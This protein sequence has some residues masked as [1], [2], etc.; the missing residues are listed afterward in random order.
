MHRHLRLIIALSAAVVVGGTGITLMGQGP[1][2]VPVADQFNRL[3][4]RS[5]GPSIMSGRVT[6]FAVYEASPATFYVGTAHGGVWKTTDNGATFAPLFQNDGLM[7]VGDL[8][9]SQK[10]PNLVW[11]GSGEGNN[12]QSISWGD[13]IFK[14]TDGGKTWKNMGLATSKHINRVRIDP[15][16]NNIV[17]VAAQ[18]PLFESGGDRG[19]YKTTDGGSTWKQ[20]L[21][22]DADTGANDLVMDPTN[23]KILYASTYQRRRSQCCMNGGGPGS[24]VWKSTDAGETWTRLTNGLPGPNLGR[25][26][27]DVYRKS[28]NILYA[29]IEAESAGGG[30][31]GGGTNA[32]TDGGLYRSDDA[33]GSWHRVNAENA[34]PMYFGQVRVD[35]TDADVVYMGGVGLHM[36]VDGGKSMEND[37]AREIHDDVHAIWIDPSNSQHLM[38]GDD[39][40]VAIS[41]DRSQHWIFQRNIVAGLFYHIDYDMDE[42]YRVCGG[43]QDNYV[44]CGPSASRTRQGI[45]DLEWTQVQGGDGFVALL[46]KRNSQIVYSETQDG[47][48]ARH[49]RVTGESKGIRPSASNVVNADPNEGNYRWN[50]DTPLVFSPTDPGVLYAAANHVFRSTDRGDSWTMISP[51]LTTNPNRGEQMIMGLKDSDVHISPNDGIS[52]WPTI[53]AFNESAKMPGVMYAGTDDGQLQVTKDGK[54]WTN[55][56]DHLTGL[57]KGGCDL[58]RRA[59][60]LRRRHGLRHVRLAPHRRLRHPHLGDARLRPDLLVAQ[61]Q[62]EERSHQDADRRPEEPG[63]PVRRRRDGHLRVARPGRELAAAQGKPARRAR[64]PNRHP[65]ARQ[66]DARRNPRPRA[67]DHGQRGANPGV[68]GQPGRRREA[69]LDFAGARV[70]GRQRHEHGVLG[71]PVLH[72]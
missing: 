69:V 17:F 41:Y 25:I 71:P 56:T 28:P 23:N 3:H 57:P 63:R 12:R 7:S 64:R 32:G 50:W 59:L 38:I 11:L 53:V 67:L 72:R 65:S 1:S 2:G 43:M 4:F 49:N 20:V 9:V 15:E 24:G 68:H 6:D 42:P 8:A 48:I 51:D 47:N 62:P 44:W 36:S 33:G 40:G 13:G 10:D 19:V 60:A 54:N 31:G 34:R 16:D 29:S 52:A 45:K 37:A 27:L 5:I 26:G 30:R 61:R 46:D 39:G 55:I 18:G 70:E 22:V 66:R 21:K 14:S 58:S 35:P